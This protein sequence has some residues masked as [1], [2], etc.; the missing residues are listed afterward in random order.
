M[1]KTWTYSHILLSGL[2]IA[3][4]LYWQFLTIRY[5]TLTFLNLFLYGGLLLGITIFLLHYFQINISDYM[6]KKLLHLFQIGCIFLLSVFILIEGSIIYSGYHE[7]SE[8]GDTVL[9]LG[10][11][12]VHG[13]H[14]SLSLLYRLQRAYEEYQKNPNV[15]IVVSGGQGSDETI[16][17]AEAMK[18][19]LVDRN[20]KES[21][22]L[23]ENRSRNTSENFRY[24]MEI[25]NKHG[26]TSKHISLVTNRFHMKRAVYLGEL[27]GFTI[28][29]KPADDLEYAQ[30]CFYTREFFGLVRAY[31]FHY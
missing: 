12:L 6:P 20:V 25:M 26:I 28:S 2:A 7:T 10:A 14:I 13:N 19:W 29:P 11:G 17:E 22:I 18:Q 15:M 23:V 21:H 1:K 31:I 30:L 5:D 8:Q 24:T 9:V 4:I 3:A 27:N 16:S